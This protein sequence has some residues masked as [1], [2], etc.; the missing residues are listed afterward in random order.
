[1]DRRCVILER[2]EDTTTEERAH[3]VVPVRDVLQRQVYLSDHLLH[4]LDIAGRQ[5]IGRTHLSLVLRVAGDL[6]DGDVQT[7]LYRLTDRQQC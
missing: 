2:R 4:M 1:M 6:A 7:P 5:L 3:L